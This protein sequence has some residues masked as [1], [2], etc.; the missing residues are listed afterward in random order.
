MR[1][2]WEYFW[3]EE[4]LD[5]FQGVLQLLEEDV[6][7]PALQFS[8][9]RDDTD[10]D[11]MMRTCSI[12]CLVSGR[13]TWKT[14]AGLNLMAASPQPPACTCSASSEQQFFSQVH[15]LHQLPLESAPPATCWRWSSTS[16]AP[17]PLSQAGQQLVSQ[18]DCA[19]KWH[20][21]M[22]DVDKCD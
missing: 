18:L 7:V 13:G 14:R 12:V 19:E 20:S 5:G 16:R 4:E 6:G 15:H 8:S 22:I 10:D 21:L 3:K 17:P 1:A 2:Q 11:F 9:L